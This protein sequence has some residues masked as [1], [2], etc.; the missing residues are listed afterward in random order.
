MK[1]IHLVNAQKDA[2]AYYAIAV[3][4]TAPSRAYIGVGDKEVVVASYNKG[5][6]GEALDVK[7]IY[8][9][10]PLAHSPNGEQLALGRQ[11]MKANSQVDL[12]FGVM[13][14]QNQFDRQ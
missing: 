14:A 3:T 11:Y 12:L 7:P 8:F 9:G 1:T 4:R 10:P 6:R 13:D 5:A 2:D